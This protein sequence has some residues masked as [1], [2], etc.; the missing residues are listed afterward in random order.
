[1]KQQ[2]TTIVIKPT[3]SILHLDLAELWTYKELFY[4]FVWRDIKVRYKQTFLGIAWAVFQ[5]L[6][7]MFIFSFFFGKLANIPSGNLPYM[8]FVYI[9]LII[10]NFFS[11]SLQ[12]A[13]S[14]M[15]ENEQ[16]IKKI[17]FPRIIIPLATIATSFVDLAI[18]S[19]ILVPLLFIFNI[20]PNP[21]ILV[22]LP[23][24]LAIVFL[25]SAGLGLFLASFN[26]KYRDVRYILPF[27][28]QILIF[29]TPVIYPSTIIADRHKWVLAL[30]PLTNVIETVRILIGGH[31]A[32]DYLGLARSFTI[33]LVIFLFGVL[34]L[35]KTERFFADIL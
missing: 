8:V 3:K 34:Y 12:N 2:V 24:L 26:V 4:S 21:V 22:F 6:T 7:T 25:T 13:S 23:L 15:V 28:V 1:M 27:F 10:W 19:L 5:P 33:A 18:T 11:A 9:G 32:I 16:L 30:N 35:K 20:T 14:S 17:Y 29:L 31:T